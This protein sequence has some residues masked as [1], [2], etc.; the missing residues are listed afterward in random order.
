MH[1]KAAFQRCS[2]FIGILVLTILSC[3]GPSSISNLFATDTPTPT[4]TFTPSPTWTP[5]PTSTP[6][7]TP[8]P[9]ATPLPTGVHAEEQADKTI[10]FSDYDNGYELLLPPN[11]EIVFSSQQEFQEAMQSAGNEDPRLAE[12]ADNFKDSDPDVFRLAAMNTDRK[13]LEASAPTLLTI[14]TIEDSVA[15]SMP[16]AF[17]TAMIEDNLLKGATS[18]TWDVINNKNG[19]EVGIV[20]GSK[21][22][23]VGKGIKLKVRELV[24]AFQTNNKLILVEIIAPEEYQNEIFTTFKDRIDMIKVSSD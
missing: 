9:T 4:S 8:S 15:S 7:V 18:T 20:E 14:D 1:Y 6:T 19:V 5:S 23:D 12:M 11:W 16:M 22:I 17:V 21:T 24:I 13:Y 2:I 3:A 10:L